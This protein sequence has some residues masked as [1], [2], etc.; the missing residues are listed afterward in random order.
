MTGAIVIPKSL[1]KGKLLTNQY[2]RT[3]VTSAMQLNSATLYSG[4][5]LF[6][7]DVAIQTKVALMVL[8]LLLAACRSE[9]RR[10]VEADSAAQVPIGPGTD[11]SALT[12]PDT[13]RTRIR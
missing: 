10:D 11:T 4:I 7:R 6:L 2:L 8:S 9:E 5:A 3:V 1:W 13:P 12:P